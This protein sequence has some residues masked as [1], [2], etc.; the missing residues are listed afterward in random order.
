MIDYSLAFANLSPSDRAALQTLCDHSGGLHQHKTSKRFQS[1]VAKGLA[2]TI[3]SRSKGLRYKVYDSVALS[4]YLW[5]RGV[6][7]S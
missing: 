1:L 6:I 5:N 2:F 3:N 7:A 4:F